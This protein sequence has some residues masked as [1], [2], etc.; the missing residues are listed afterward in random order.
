MDEVS[1]DRLGSVLAQK[2]VPVLIR[3][4]EGD[5]PRLQLP[6]AEGNRGWLRA[7]GMT[8]P[9][10]IA[11]D[12]QWEVPQARFT[13]LVNRCLERFGKVWVVQPHN[14]Q[15]KCA[16][17]CWDAE[18]EECQCSCMGVNHG[19]RG[20]AGRWKIISDSFATRWLGAHMAARLI[21]RRS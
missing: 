4:G 16:P 21:Q 8:N 14:E 1:G 17:A 10:W 7:T 2:R 15:E 12:K 9:K 20:P 6:F 13:E 19:S 3:R 11:A 5:R 18:R